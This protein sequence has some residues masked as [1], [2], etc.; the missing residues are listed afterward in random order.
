[1]CEE[2]KRRKREEEIREA[3]EVRTEGRVWEIIRRERGE[4]KSVKKGSENIR[5]EKWNTS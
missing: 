1:M 2:K 4:R 5:K 3:K